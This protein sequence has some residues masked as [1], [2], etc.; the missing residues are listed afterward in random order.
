MKAGFEEG[1]HDYSDLQ[2]EGNHIFPITISGCG[3]TELFPA[4]GLSVITITVVLFIGLA[5]MHIP[6]LTSPI[7]RMQLHLL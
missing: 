2:D 1:Q 7:K 3:K 6:F 4:S 5:L